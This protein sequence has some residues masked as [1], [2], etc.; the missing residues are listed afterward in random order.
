M[1]FL[2]TGDWHVGRTLRGRSRSDEFWASLD[3]VVGIATSEGVDAVLVAGDLYD[4]RALSAEADTIVF[5]TLIKLHEA[6]IPVVA[7]PGN[8]DSVA[9]LA[10]LAP[11]LERIGVT[12]VPKV[13]PPASG[14]SIEVPARDGEES[15]LIACLPFV[16]PRRFSDATQLF[17]DIAAGYVSFDEGMGG[18]L[19]ALAGG[20]QTSRVNIML[21]HLFVSGAKPGG[22]ERQITIGADY[23]VSPA[24]LP[25][26]AHYIALGHIHRPQ[27]VRAAPAP[28]RYCGSLLQLDFG[29]RE[30]TKSVVIV[31]AEPGRRARTKEITIAA[32]RQLLDVSASLDA[33]PGLASRVGDAYLRVTIL[34]DGP[35]PGIA[36]RV[37]EVLPNALDVKLEYEREEEGRPE[38]S[39]RSLEPRE[40]FAAYYRDRQGAEPPD[41]LVT[42]FDRIHDEVAS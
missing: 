39:L 32:G 12:A 9:R 34:T 13:K 21:G 6:H 35:A 10:A 4:Q 27:A 40:Q 5:E 26:T 15:A 25:G 17:G 14:G 20:F 29:E 7:I 8:H 28:T 3:E 1:R 11:L 33:L 22:G 19:S 23:A 16:S 30:Q 42:A 18:L 2:H 31:D 36:D 24:K 38:I 37:R 41:A